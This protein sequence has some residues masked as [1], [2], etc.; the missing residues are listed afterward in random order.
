[1]NKEI[2][3]PSSI[4][5]AIPAAFLATCA[6]DYVKG[7]SGKR[8]ALNMLLHAGAATL[9]GLSCLALLTNGEGTYEGKVI[10]R[11]KDGKPLWKLS[12]QDGKCRFDLG[13]LTEDQ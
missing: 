6:W 10:Y 9:G 4:V 2:T 7:V 1:M 5:L 13:G 12:S 3:I 11:Q 8:I